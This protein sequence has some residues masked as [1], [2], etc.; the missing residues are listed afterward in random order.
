MNLIALW[1]G[2]RGPCRRESNVME[3][4]RTDLLSFT[5]ASVGDFTVSRKHFSRL[6]GPIGPSPGI[7]S[8]D[9]HSLNGSL[10]PM[11]GPWTHPAAI[12]PAFISIPGGAVA[13]R[14]GQRDSP[15]FAELID[16]TTG[17]GH[18]AH[19]LLWKSP[20]FP[21][22]APWKRVVRS[23]AQLPFI[24][25][26]QPVAVSGL[27]LLEPNF[28]A[29]RRRNRSSPASPSARRTALPAF[30]APSFPVFGSKTSQSKIASKYGAAATVLGNSCVR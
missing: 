11:F 30:F 8:T 18:P 4:H 24:L 19:P 21:N 13:N 15:G 22:P 5:T 20:L 29:L 10:V 23:L 6:A 25:F 16:F 1:I 7:F 3:R 2:G 9:D 28:D 27:T 26:C 12:P 14:C 17:R